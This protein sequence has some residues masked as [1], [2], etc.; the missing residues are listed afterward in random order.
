VLAR[1]VALLRDRGIPF[2]VV[3]AAAMAVHGVSRATRD[4]DVLVLD[5]ACLAEATWSSLQQCGVAVT[6]RRG[7]TDDPLA[8]VVRLVVAGE[9]P[10]DVI[11]GKSSWQARALGRA[12]P[13]V[14]DGVATPVA[15]LADLLLLKLYAGGPQDAWDV[16]QLLEAGDR[17][18]LVA[19][20]EASLAA[21]PEASRR[22]WS[23]VVQSG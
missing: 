11:V 16:A 5:P 18:A 14:I 4:V 23:R 1:V 20:V 9:S 10:V 3:G 22:L 19:E 21:L 2:A 6:I 7:D 12:L 8:G 17:P 13:R 15:S